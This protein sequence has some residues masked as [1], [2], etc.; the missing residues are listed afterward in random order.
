MLLCSIDRLPRGQMMR[1]PPQRRGHTW[2]QQS[3]T[4]TCC[5]SCSF[6]ID[7]PGGLQAAAFAER[8]A[9]VSDK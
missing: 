7:L 2:R 8:A 5:L 4:L 3:L 9:G 6:S 1:S